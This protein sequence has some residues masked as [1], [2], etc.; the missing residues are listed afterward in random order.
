[1]T[2]YNIKGYIARDA[3]GALFFHSKKP[4]RFNCEGIKYWIG[5]YR[6]LLPKYKESFPEL[7]WEDDPV[8]IEMTIKPAI[9][10]E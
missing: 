7:T 1:M 5:G 8:E 2:D 3:D 9:K 6:F 4:T 10:N